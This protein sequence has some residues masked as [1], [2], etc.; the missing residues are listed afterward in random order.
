[1][2]S[3]RRAVTARQAIGDLPPITSLR[4]G[5]LHSGPRRFDAPCG[6]RRG[7]PSAYARE[8]R[9]WAGFEAPPDGPSDHVIRYLPRDWPIFER[10][11]PAMSILQPM[12]SPRCSLRSS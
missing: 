7:R 12:T 6:Y 8:M 9:H 5:T 2:D 10:M 11:R 4:D 1:M 3:L